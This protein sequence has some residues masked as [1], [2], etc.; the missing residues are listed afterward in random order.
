MCSGDESAAILVNEEDHLRL[1]VLKP[2]FCLEEAWQQLDAIDTKLSGHL[3]YAFDQT[4]G[5]LTCCP[6]NVGTGMRA[7]VMLHLPGLVFSKQITA[8]IQGVNKLGFAV[9]GIFG[10]GTANRGNLFQ[11]SNQSTLGE[12]EAQIIDHLSAIIRQLISH[13]ENTRKMI[14]VRD[15]YGVMNQVGRAYGLLKHAYKLTL[16]EALDALSGIRLGADLG[17]FNSVSVGLVNE[18][19]AK[20]GTAHLEQM[21]GKSLTPAEVEI[22]RATF[23]REKLSGSR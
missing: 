5:Y 9:R 7:S 2:G 13:E 19:F 17:M 4:L 6:T 16:E 14:L 10:E 18:L 21:A 20:C 15:R 8:V 1:Q 11:I 23:F 12:S 3:D 22:Q